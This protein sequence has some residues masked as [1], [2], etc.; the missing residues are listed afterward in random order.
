MAKKSAGLRPD[1]Y[2]EGGGLLDN[3]DVVWNEVRFETWDYG[4]RGPST[5]ALKVGMT[6]VDSGDEVEQYYSAGKAQDW[7]PSDDGTELVAIG[8]ASGIN[9]NS[10]TAILINSLVEAGFPAEK[11]GDDCSILDGLE[12]HM[13]RIPAPERKGI[14]NKPREDGATYVQ[15][16][17]VVDS[18]TKLPWDKAATKKGKGASK[19]AKEVEEGVDDEDLNEKVMDA[20][21][22]ILS[23]EEKA[24]SKKVL[25]AK[26]HKALKGDDDRSEAVKL[27]MDDGFL[28][29]G[30]WE[31]NAKKGMVGG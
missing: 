10:N 17:L 6:V 8:K 28:E 21:I 9:K 16:V 24:I 29:E 31:F 1:D 2:S 3:E 26:V 18:I 13:V 15:T 27:V 7:E 22:E 14:I 25:A 11:L 20:V 23:E 12:C 30:P 5:P 19:K 4:G